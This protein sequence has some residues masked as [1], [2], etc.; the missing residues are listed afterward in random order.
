MSY[1]RNR[2]LDPRQQG[3]GRRSLPAP[4]GAPTEQSEK[5]AAEKEKMAQQLEAIERQD[6]GFCSKPGGWAAG[7]FIEAA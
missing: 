7:R 1:L 6:A 3:R 4:M 5:L 2:A